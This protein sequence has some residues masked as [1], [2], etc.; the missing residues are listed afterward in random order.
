MLMPRTTP[1]PRR[2]AAQLLVWYNGSKG[3]AFVGR[4]IAIVACRPTG[5]R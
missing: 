3:D 2:A 5:G 4:T 1:S